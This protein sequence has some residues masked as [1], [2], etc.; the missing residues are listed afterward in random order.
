MHHVSHNDTVKCQMCYGTILNDRG[1]F[2]KEF[3]DYL[4]TFTTHCK[5]YKVYKAFIKHIDLQEYIKIKKCKHACILLSCLQKRG[6]SMAV[7]LVKS[8][9]CERWPSYGVCPVLASDLIRLSA[10][11]HV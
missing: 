6:S 2:R 5:C 7:V 9:G 3:E 4:M 10:P 11:A 8:A 1:K